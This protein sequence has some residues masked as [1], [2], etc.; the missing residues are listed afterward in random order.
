M[1]LLEESLVVV[2]Q[3]PRCRRE[4]EEPILLT[5]LSVTP[6]EQYDACPHCFTKLE[7]KTTV[8]QEVTDKNE[9]MEETKDSD[10]QLLKKVEDLILSS[11]VNQQ[12]EKKTSSCPQVFGYLGNRP[13][14]APIPQECLVCKRIMDCMLRIEE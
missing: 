2:C 12:K 6:P 8:N 7:P 11:N 14:D 3:N 13:A 4:I 9:V 10:P 1:R 5:N